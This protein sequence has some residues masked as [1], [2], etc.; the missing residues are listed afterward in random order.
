MILWYLKPSFIFVH[1]FHVSFL[2][3]KFDSTIFYLL[4]SHSSVTLFPIALCHLFFLLTPS[5]YKA[6]YELFTLCRVNTHESPKLQ[7]ITLL[8]YSRYTNRI[9][10]L[11]PYF[12]LFICT[13]L[14]IILKICLA[15]FSSYNSFVPFVTYFSKIM[16]EISL[17]AERNL[18]S[19]LIKSLLHQTLIFIVLNR[20][21]QMKTSERAN[22][23]RSTNTVL[24]S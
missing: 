13:F 20:W 14:L 9:A 4:V 19:V 1:S 22:S 18:N 12:I 11:M 21:G 10:K 3:F 24:S 2:S 16:H 6:Y 7:V 23:C 15:F 5:V 8:K 17:H